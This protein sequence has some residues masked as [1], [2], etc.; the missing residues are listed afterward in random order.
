MAAFT[1]QWIHSSVALGLF[2]Y[3]GWHSETPTLRVILAVF[4]EHAWPWNDGGCLLAG[5]STFAIALRGFAS[6]AST[7][8]FEH[9][10]W[11]K[12]SAIDA[13]VAAEPTNK[14]YSPIPII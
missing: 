6:R 11:P 14:Y 5:L 8:F 13:F 10:H 4:A 3:P 7:S 12:C 9:L 1:Q 2:G